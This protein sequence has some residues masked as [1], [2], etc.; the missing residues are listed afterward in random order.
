MIH[1]QLKAVNIELTDALQEYVNKRIASLEKFAK[2]DCNAYVEVG[3]TTNHHKSGDVFKAEI[4]LTIDGKTYRATSETSDL[5]AAVDDVKDDLFETI[6]S[7]K[8]R[9]QTLWKRGA[10]SVKKMLKGISKRNPFTSKY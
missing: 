9:N 4:N 10:R 2:G 1:T 6:T 3:K 5:Y 7:E 8:D